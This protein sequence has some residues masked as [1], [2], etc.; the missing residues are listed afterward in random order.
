MSPEEAA[1]IDADRI[2]RKR[3][4]SREWHKKF[5]SKGVARKILFYFLM[6]PSDFSRQFELRLRV[7]FVSSIRFCPSN[8]NPMLRL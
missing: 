7:F 5:E 3:E 8:L 6:A 2:T 1:R 4:K